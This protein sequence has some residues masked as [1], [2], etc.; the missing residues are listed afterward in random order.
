MDR[1]CLRR[2]F[3]LLLA[4]L[5]CA[6]TVV[7]RESAE[8]RL[9]HEEMP[10]GGAVRLENLLGSIQV[11]PGQAGSKLRVEARVVAEA[12]T[13]EE[14][15]ALA[16]AISLVR[17]ERDGTVVI[18]VDYPVEQ[19]AA[20]RVPRSERDG[21]YSKWVAPL[22]R[23]SS[24]S[25]EYDGQLVEVG[26][27]KGAAAVVVHVKINLPLDLDASLKQY[28]GTIR[29]SGLRGSLN[30]EIVEGE[31]SAEQIYGNLRA[32]TGSGELR[33][34]KYRGDLFE[35][36]TGSGRID[37][38]D[39]NAQR[40]RL[41][42]GSGSIRGSAIQAAALVVKTGSGDVELAE[43][44]P[45]LFEV[46]TA[47][48]DVDLASPLTRTREGSIRTDSGDV[49][50]RVGRLTPFDLTAA[51]GSG[52]VK[53][54]GVSLEL[55]EESEDGAHFRRRSGGPSLR[56]DTGAKGKVLVREI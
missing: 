11:M 51:A 47:S 23:R 50:L 32:R 34:W 53:A 4:L 42:T 46:S 54:Q 35:L 24:V 49:T 20:F 39:I 14:A 43:L 12:E 41:T 5:L 30:L 1:G 16:D 37:L 18:R 8:E 3:I 31:V 44:E 19:Q 9:T 52:A 36:Q 22:V 40:M 27:A 29:C 33:I 28:V 25:A 21:L 13:R 15:D 45:A 2:S 38:T 26:D 55:L 48:G 7:A 10:A 17:E 56:V 6:G